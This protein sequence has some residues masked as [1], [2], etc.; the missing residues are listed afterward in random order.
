MDDGTRLVRVEGRCRANRRM[1]ID[2]SKKNGPRR[3]DMEG[4][5]GK[6]RKVG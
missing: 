3:Y 1:C 4:K 5:Q 6:R 2:I